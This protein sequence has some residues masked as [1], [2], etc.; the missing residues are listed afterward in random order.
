M[1]TETFTRKS[2]PGRDPET[3]DLPKIQATQVEFR[4]FF[5]NAFIGLLAD[6]NMRLQLPT[7]M[8]ATGDQ[9]Y[10]SGALAN[11]VEDGS[12]DNMLEVAKNVVEV[13]PRV[14][15][16]VKQPQIKQN[17]LTQRGTPIR[18]IAVQDD[19]PRV[20][21]STMRRIPVDFN[22][23]LVAVASNWLVGL[24]LYEHLISK[25]YKLNAYG[26]A[27]AGV[28][29]GASYDFNVSNVDAQHAIMHD[30]NAK[31]CK[32]ALQLTLHLQYPAINS[33]DNVWGGSDVIV[34]WIHNIHI[35][36]ESHVN[37][38]VADDSSPDLGL[39]LNITFKGGLDINYLNNMKMSYL[40]NG[41]VHLNDKFT[42][43]GTSCKL[44]TP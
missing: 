40:T 10:W 27:W 14:V 19:M 11:T 36:D 26:F 32:I 13:V 25:L 43:T 29:N 41:Q 23:E 31:D 21:H 20:L 6:L 34:D 24:D 33:K 22:V 16:E 4:H 7:Y 18:L 1:S 9:R 2:G 35:V 30:N 17:A 8:L 12:V 39:D 44:D 38:G 28:I 5:R 37:A 42:C 3:L 15:V